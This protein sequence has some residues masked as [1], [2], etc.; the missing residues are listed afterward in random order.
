M[1]AITNWC[2]S[3]TSNMFQQQLNGPML[4][5]N[6]N[7]YESGNCSPWSYEFVTISW[8]GSKMN[9]TVM[10]EPRRGGRK[11]PNYFDHLFPD[12]ERWSKKAEPSIEQPGLFRPPFRGWSK[13][14]EQ[15]FL[16][17]VTPYRLATHMLACSMISAVNKFVDFRRNEW[18]R[19]KRGQ[20][21]LKNR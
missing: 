10:L 9:C 20:E 18:D 3:S 1:G 7:R 21:F 14:A 12:P 17:S 16:G 2:A 8:N 11:K 13:K 19:Q 6:M 4:S 5:V 15:P